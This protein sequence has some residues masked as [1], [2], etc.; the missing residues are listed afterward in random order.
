MIKNY[1][2]TS[3]FTRAPNHLSDSHL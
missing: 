3:A 1:F 2:I